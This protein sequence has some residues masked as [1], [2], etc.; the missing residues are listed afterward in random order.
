MILSL[1]KTRRFSVIWILCALITLYVLEVRGALFGVAKGSFGYDGTRLILF[2]HLSAACLMGFVLALVT[3]LAIETKRFRVVWLMCSTIAFY[4]LLFSYLIIA[5]FP[6][7][8]KT[9]DG[10]SVIGSD[11]YILSNW[12]ELEIR[13]VLFGETPVLIFSD[14]TLLTLLKH[15]SASCLIG[16]VLALVSLMAIKPADNEKE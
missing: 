7:E 12:Y 11:S 14:N 6:S 16:L 8:Y 1:V 10:R 9:E 15:V 2:W 13:R 4:I 3:L 5:S